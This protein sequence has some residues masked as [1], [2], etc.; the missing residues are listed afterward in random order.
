MELALTVF[1]VVLGATIV[2][3]FVGYLIDRRASHHTRS[4]GR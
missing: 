1:A 3:A 4:E 2:L